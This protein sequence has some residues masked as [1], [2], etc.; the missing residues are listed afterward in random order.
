MTRE[1]EG[2]KVVAGRPVSS[3]LPRFKGHVA[4]SSL[5]R[6]YLSI[7]G[8]R[9]VFESERQ[10]PRGRSA[11]GPFL[12]GGAWKTVLLLLRPNAGSRKV[13]FN[14]S[15]GAGCRVISRAIGSKF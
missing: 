2:S 4:V 12:C 3:Y 11:N 10:S 6:E 1:S 7:G 15:C 8:Q 13:L 9:A 14:S 5:G